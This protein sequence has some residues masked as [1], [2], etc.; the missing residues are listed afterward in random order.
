MRVPHR[1]L[2]ASVVAAGAGAAAVS[3]RRRQFRSLAMREARTVLADAHASLG[4]DQLSAKWH[5]LPDPIQRHLHYAIGANAPA[6]RVARLRHDGTFRTA[7]D[8]RWMPIEGEQYFAVSSPGFVWFATLHLA[9]FLWIQARD[10]FVSGRGSMLVKPLSLFAVADASG[11]EIDQGSALR[12]LA[13]SLWFPYALVS[14]AIE[15]ESI[16]ARSARA[17]LRRDG[18]ATR[19]VFEIDE[20]GKI[21]ALHAD[22]YRDVGNGRSVLDAWSGRYRDYIECSGFRVPSSVEVTWNLSSGPF[23]YAR[24]RITTLEYNVAEPFEAGGRRWPRHRE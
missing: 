21:A 5:T 4:P 9:P 11:P 23:S 13:E 8:Q 2:V 15:W 10:C 6:L 12:W 19:A 1:L 14:D 16:D 22:R 7:P 24:F 18:L 3:V 20:E 17:T